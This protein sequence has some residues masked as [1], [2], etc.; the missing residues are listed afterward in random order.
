MELRLFRYFV[1][2]AREKNIT[3]AAEALYITQPTLSRQL[4]CLEDMMGA[5]LFIRGKYE[6]TLTEP[7]KLLYK[8]A[9]EMLTLCDIATRE[10]KEQ[11]EH[12]SGT[13]YIGAN[14]SVCTRV[15][16]KWI[17]QFSRIYPD[18]RYD[19][20]T[21]NTITITERMNSG[22]ID[23][24]ILSESVDTA[25][26]DVIPLKEHEIWGVVMRSD[27][28]LAS[29]EVL[30]V[31]DIKTLPLMTTKRPSAQKMI[32]AWF[33]ESGHNIN[34]FITANSISTA[35]L[36]V[37]KGL[38]YILTIEGVMSHWDKN[39]LR[40]IPLYPELLNVAVMTWRK[41]RLLGK[42]VI[43]FIEMVKSTQ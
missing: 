29:K 23:V 13:I 14:Q 33:G 9:E 17:D 12:M 30:T 21:G 11:S 22:L 19:I 24:G 6:I 38:A 32:D 37:M 8:R 2:L 26:Y 34:Q 42:A 18:V 41:D 25:I 10:V 31:D 15:L 4:K 7:G 20:Y 36:L 5:Q 43:A 40:F 28:A 39:E 16:P 1:T 3:K 27:D 35:A